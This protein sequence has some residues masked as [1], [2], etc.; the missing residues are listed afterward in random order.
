MTVNSISSNTYQY[1]VNAQNNFQQ[2]QQAISS[3]TSSI[4]NNNV[5]GANQ[6]LSTLTQ[7][8]SQMINGNPTQGSQLSNNANTISADL[9][10][11]G[12]DLQS[13]NISA[14]QTDLNQLLQDL[15]NIQK[16]HHRHH[17][18]Y[19]TNSQDLTSNLSNPP[20]QTSGSGPDCSNTGSNNSSSS[21]GSSI[22]VMA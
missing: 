4:Q 1:Q 21:N 15:Q 16:G 14:A 9:T 11:I 18:P 19:N 7:L 6:A 12:K 13:G 3:L 10:A 17:G 2:F 8:M 5:N 20:G 22:N